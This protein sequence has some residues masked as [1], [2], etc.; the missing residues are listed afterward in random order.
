LAPV[1]EQVAAYYRRRVEA[2]VER[3]T[4]VIEPV[5][6]LGM[7]VTVAVILASIYLPMFQMAS[8]PR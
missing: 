6:I 3:L 1:L 2:M 5:V 4:K 8:G 7:G